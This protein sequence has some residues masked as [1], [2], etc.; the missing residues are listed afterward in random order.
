M[1]ICVTVLHGNITNLNKKSIGNNEALNIAKLLRKYFEVDFLTCKECDNCIHVDE[2]Y[3]INQYDA[4][5]VVNG[6][7]NMFGGLEIETAT[8]IY[9]LM[10][11]FDKQ[12]YYL[13]TDLLMPFVDYYKHISGKEF[14]IYQPNDFSLKNDLIIISQFSNKEYV[15]KI[16]K[17]VNIKEIY[18][19]PLALW[20]LSQYEEYQSENINTFNNHTTDLIYGGSF[21]AGNRLNKMVDYFFNR[22]ID[23]KLY[24]NIKLSQFKKDYGKAPEFE[25]KVEPW[26]V[27][28]KNGEGL[29][30]IIIGDKNYNN[31]TITLRVI[32]SL[33]SDCICFIDEDFDTNRKIL[34]NDDKNDYSFFYVKD[35]KELENKIR[36]IKNGT[37]NYNALKEIQ[38][39][40]VM[41]LK[42]INIAKQ[43][44]EILEQNGNCNN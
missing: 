31:N 15:R 32:E 42:E 17:G 39:N 37:L 6:S 22:N 24:G 20:Y 16:H 35:G 1:K 34:E 23:V 28:R 21:R 19:V 12:V 3:D 8:T 27:M 4:M 9:K 10:H 33:L 7:V 11:K 14:N 43:I 38:L 5:L 40:K 18:Y 29:A 36:M 25:K 44:K 2:N 26:N 30:T 13:L 41:K